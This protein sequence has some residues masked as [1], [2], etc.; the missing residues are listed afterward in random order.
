[1]KL[2]LLLALL[3][4]SLSFADDGLPTGEGSFFKYGLGLKTKDQESIS[5][6]KMFSI[7]R[8]SPLLYILDQKWEVGMWSDQ[9]GD[10]RKSSGFGGW[11]MGVEP[12]IGTFYVHSFWGVIGITTT[13]SM[14]GSNLQF[15]QDLGMGVRDARGVGIGVGYKHI[16]DAG[17]KMP[18][19][20][21]DFFFAQ[22]QI[23]L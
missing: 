17:I 6:V 8:Q 22:L 23:P 16:S 9:H 11:S 2:L 5:E 3:V 21:R 13:D 12:K 15:M 7:G 19:K 20:G 14:L 18:N 10:G 4:P 1:M